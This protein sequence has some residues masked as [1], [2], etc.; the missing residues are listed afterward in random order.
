[1][2]RTSYSPLPR[3]AR[4]PQKV[5]SPSL[6]PEVPPRLVTG[7]RVTLRR[8]PPP[9]TTHPLVAQV[10]LIKEMTHSQAAQVRRMEERVPR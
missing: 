5:I 9:L 6:L 2:T 8:R 1:M 4:A 7:G 3:I 10:C